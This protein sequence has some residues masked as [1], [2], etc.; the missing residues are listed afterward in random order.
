MVACEVAH[1]LFN[2]PTKIARVRAQSYLKPEWSDLFN[3]KHISIDYIISP[4]IEVARA[5]HRRI[6]TPGAF[7]M[8]PFADD[9]LRLIGVLLD[10]HCPVLT[11]P[12][13]QLTD[14]FP[15]LSVTV[16]GIIRNENGR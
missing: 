16:R 5:I 7:D 1:A 14:L 9:R 6:L 3:E 11:K 13:R 2:V 4:E 12:L 10:D 15:H 8:V